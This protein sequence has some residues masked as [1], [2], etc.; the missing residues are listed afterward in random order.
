MCLC[1][2]DLFPFDLP[3]L[4]DRLHS[5]LSLSHSLGVRVRGVEGVLPLTHGLNSSVQS[6]ASL[7]S[8]NQLANKSIASCIAN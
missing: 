2:S 5:S 1:G 8:F 3:G 6:V 7:L 4:V